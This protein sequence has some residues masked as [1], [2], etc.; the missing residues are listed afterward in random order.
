[1]SDPSP[2][3]REPAPPGRYQP[4]APPPQA[5]PANSGLRIGLGLGLLVLP[6]AAA[7]VAYLLPTL[8]TI[9]LSFQSGSSMIGGA[10]P[11]GTE[12][13]S[14]AF[15]D[16]GFLEGLTSVSLLALGTV[17]AGAVMAPLVAW[18]LHSGGAGVRMAARI[19]WSV[20]VIAFAPA[21]MTIAW[22][23]A[24][25]ESGRNFTE[26]DM[27]QWA[28]LISGTV[29]GAGVLV[30]LAAFRGGAE[31]AK[32]AKAVVTAAGLTA[33][34][35]AAASLQAFTFTYITGVPAPPGMTPLNNVFHD[36]FRLLDSGYAAAKSTVLLAIL[37]VLGIGAALLFI[38]TRTRIEV[39]PGPGRPERFRPGA[40]IAGILLL[41][42]FGAGVVVNLLPWLTR[43]T[44]ESIGSF[45]RTE[46]LID[47]W[48]PPLITTAVALVTAA[49]GGFAIGAL[50][51]LGEGSRWL[52]LLFAPWLFVGSGPLAVVGYE[53]LAEADA[54]FTF[55][56]LVPRA[57]IAVPA[58]FVFT[59]LF[60]GLEDR[61]RSMRALGAPASKA[62]GAF[63]AAAWPLVAL[64]GMVL[65]L[66]HAND[67]F[68]QTVAGQKTAV[69][70][71]L[72]ALH[73]FQTETAGVGIGYPFALLALF[74]AAMVAAAVF[75]LPRV[76]IRVG[77]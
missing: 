72:Q 46:V 3:P 36:G 67:T 66:V 22:L 10:E 53:S 43:M 42:L 68:W 45:D 70:A 6:L 7:V 76:G 26:A 25:M 15:G 12:N 11:A 48:V 49:A 34:A 44:G 69:Q 61:R 23:L 55:G 35:L 40:G 4:S 63:A 8:R 74:A 14:R 57:W 38:L 73:S 60:W 62:N 27:T 19:V 51:P 16:S 52:L 1:M 32:P 29:F 9:D 13:Y 5:P 64:V 24:H 50:R 17:V 20:A 21:A 75:Y 65:W 59:A 31:P 41:I 37:A 47:T 39:S 56:G 33:L 28:A 54:V 18:C 58:L 71:M 2:Y 30:A 77:R